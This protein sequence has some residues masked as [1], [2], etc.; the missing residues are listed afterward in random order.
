MLQPAFPGRSVTSVELLTAG[1]CNTNYK[2]QVAGLDDAFVL[3]I[4]TRDRAACQ[5]DVDILALVQERVPVPEMLYSHT[6]DNAEDTTYAV[7]TWADGVLLSDVMVA[8]DVTALAACAYE[9]G[10]T[11]AAIGSYTFPHAGF[12]GPGLT[13]AEAFEDS[14]QTALAYIEQSLFNAR[15]GQRLGKNLTQRLWHFVTANA[16][17]F[18]LMD[19]VATLVHSDFK[20]FNILVHEVQKQWRISAVLDWEFAFA[21]SPLVDIGN[22][23]RYDRLLPPA[24][25][26]QF[27][28]G[29]QEQGGH[30]PAAWRKGAKLS[31][32][33]S[34]CEF[35]DA[36]TTN[37][38]KLQEVTG[39]IIDT[40][41]Y[42][43]D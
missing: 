12:F 4:Y 39:L 43:H 25:T 35:L 33:V 36:P 9:A 37:D 3:R 38:A 5:K 32:L 8:S 40:L 30:L 31:D 10:K 16:G 15:A 26:A 7:T 14:Q 17:Y 27:I 1:K 20:G 34:L 19:E 22:M 29:Y 11:L 42:W 21:G 23:L 6:G 24:F 18:A 13:I 41:T 2:I 28:H